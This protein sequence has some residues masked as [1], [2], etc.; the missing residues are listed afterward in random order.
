MPPSDWCLTHDRS[1]TECEEA[2][3]AAAPPVPPA[4]EAADKSDRRAV[5]SRLPYKPWVNSHRPCAGGCHRTFS[6]PVAINPNVPLS[7]RIVVYCAECAVRLLTVR[8]GVAYWQQHQ[9]GH[10]YECYFGVGKHASGSEAGAA[11]TPL[12]ADEQTAD[13]HA[14]EGSD[15]PRAT[16][17]IPPYDARY[18][19]ER[20]T[21]AELGNQHPLDLRADDDVQWNLR[22]PAA[23]NDRIGELQQQWFPEYEND[24]LPQ[25]RTLRR[26]IAIGLSAIDM[27]ERRD[28][29]FVRSERRA[30]ET[31][32]RIIDEERRKLA[33]EKEAAKFYRPA[34][35]PVS[36]R[37]KCSC[38]APNPGGGFH[39]WD[40]DSLDAGYTPDRNAEPSRFTFGCDP[41]CSC[42]EEAEFSLPDALI[43]GLAAGIGLL[44]GRLIS[45]WTRK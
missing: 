43:L 38:N 45:R 16:Q 13:K 17:P 6:T 37:K 31:A 3:S 25:S 35:A 33:V 40:C 1:I 7:D 21:P 2:Y 29:Q 18:A 39:A 12:R 34:E 24:W 41:D 9:T 27:L 20:R 5:S 8:D 14:R 26:V 15:M 32:L 42:C 4:N 10:F 44:A 19:G 22:M 30:T 36:P 11:A 28:T 23:A